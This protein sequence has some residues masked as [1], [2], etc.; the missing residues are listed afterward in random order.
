MAAGLSSASVIDAASRLIARGGDETVHWSQIATEAGTQED[1]STFGLFQNVPA[2]VDACYARSAQTLEAA[3]LNGETARGS[4]LD[5]LAAFLVCVLQMRRERGSL[6]PL[7]AGSEVPQSRQKRLRERDMMIR[8][9]LRRLL[10]AGQRDGSIAR[11]SIDC[12]CELILA[13]LQARRVT[14]DGPDQRMRDADLTEMLLAAVAEP[15][16]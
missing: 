16:R 10:T 9:R 11:R 13:T 5:K 12:A 6:L 7:R 8:V 14:A 3:L 1:D 4:G 2:I 15:I